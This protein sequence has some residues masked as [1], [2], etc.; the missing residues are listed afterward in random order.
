[1]ASASVRGRPRGPAEAT[2]S[3]AR[4]ILAR[5]EG[6]GDGV[7]A[8]E[9]VE[10]IAAQEGVA[11]ATVWNWIS[12]ARGKFT[13]VDSE[14][15]AAGEAPA[16]KPKPRMT[17][18]TLLHRA[19]I[20]MCM[21]NVFR[22]LGDAVAMFWLRTVLEIH[23]LGEGNGL[24]FG[25]PGDAYRSRREFAEAAGRTEAELDDLVHR[26]LLAALAGGGIDLP[27]RF[28]L[29][30]REPVGGNLMFAGAG[31]I[32]PITPRAGRGFD[33]RQGN[34][35]PM[36]MPGPRQAD[37]SRNNQSAD[38]RNNQSD[39]SRN[40]PGFL[41]E[42]G[43]ADSRN[44]HL[45]GGEST[46]KNNN[47]TEESE[48]FGVVVET[49]GTGEADADSSE[50]PAGD[51]RNNPPWVALTAELIGLVGR[52]GHGTPAEMS[53]V[54]GWLDAG[55]G[56][57]VI[58]ETIRE[59]MARKRHPHSPS[60]AYFDV[61]VRDMGAAQPAPAALAPAAALSPEEHALRALL[62][63]ANDAWVADRSCPFPPD[64]AS[65]KAAVAAGHGPLAHRW[66]AVWVAWH[67]AGRPRDGRPP[68]FT[69]LP[70]SPGTFEADLI[71]C[72]DELTAPDTPGG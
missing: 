51:S 66:L 8:T 68:H 22:L 35:P 57:N 36:G 39:D 3:K 58:R 24:S 21:I 13:V 5:H 61:R 41:G 2:Q 53:V 26:G 31:S 64:P 14:S 55:I 23:E 46:E 37:D 19:W 12:D 48:S 7:S 4:E 34:L 47:N 32:P 1:M 70:R 60:L 69:M 18:R 45:A 40:N 63:P 29:R 15:S 62:K 20:A 52:P 30:P 27:F 67:A 38:S 59:L 33:P 54:R 9:S 71:A 43:S 17:Q 50:I 72:E 6:R 44:I 49:A 11:T 28:G 65:F 56:P 16:P 42:S 25:E 10:A